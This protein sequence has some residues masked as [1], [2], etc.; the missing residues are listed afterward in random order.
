MRHRA[1][2]TTILLSYVLAASSLA[3]KSDFPALKCPY[4]GQNPPE[5]KPELF[6]PGI[7]SV[8]ENFEHS[9]IAAVFWPCHQMG[10]IC[11]FWARA[12]YGWMLPLSKN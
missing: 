9:T 10:N 6:T 7:I 1:F 12:Y 4:L 2:I 3:Q 8:D 11:S 5:K